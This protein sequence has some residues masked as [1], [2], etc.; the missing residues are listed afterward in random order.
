MRASLA[1]WLAGLAASLA[2]S[3]LAETALPT[4]L[5]ETGYL[6]VPVAESQ[7]RGGSTF[8]LDL[9]YS[10]ASDIGRNVMPSPLVMSFGLGRGEAGFSLRQGGLPGDSRPYATIPSGAGKFTLLEEHGKRPALAVDLVL[11]QLTRTPAIHMRGIATSLRY[12]RMRASAFA[13]WVIGIDRP[14][15]WTAGA[16]LSVVGPRLTEF[17]VEGF[18]QPG[19]L[20]IGAGLRWLP[21]QKFVVGLGATYLPDD[22]KTLQAGVTVAFLHPAP[23]KLAKVDESEQIQEEAKPKTGK[24]RFT[25]ERPRFALQLRER[26]SPGAEGG[27]A[28][29]FPGSAPAVTTESAPAPPSTKAEQP[30]GPSEP[31]ATAKSTKEST[32]E[33]A[34]TTELSPDAGVA[35]ARPDS[36]AEPIHDDHRD[37]GLTPSDAVPDASP[38]QVEQGVATGDN[39]D[40]APP[41]VPPDA[42]PARVER[43]VPLPP[44]LKEG[45]SGND[46]VRQ[47]IASFQPAIKQCVDRALKRDTALRGEARIDFEV[48]PS[49]RVKLRVIHSKTLAGGWFEDCVRQAAAMWRMPRTPKGYEL[50]IPIK[51]R[52]ANGGSP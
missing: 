40:T 43:L 29:H 51:L 10:Q 37:A 50:E 47:A 31:P 32:T 36:S 15:G 25:S 9:R 45:T 22:A 11:D 4:H 46:Q 48:L 41:S 27:P 44:T 8:A 19:G 12:R 5:G 30:V 23:P 39:P 6:D 13:G 38:E 33:S 1:A 21:L 3:A 52:I 14:S 17:F 18:H 49:G 26:Q 34:P 35:Q 28:P 42:A 20:L 2:A 16:A 24:R 7:G